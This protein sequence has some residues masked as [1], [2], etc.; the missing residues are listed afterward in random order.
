MKEIELFFTYR[1]DNAVLSYIFAFVILTESLS[2][3]AH[4]SV[5]SEFD[6]WLNSLKLQVSHLGFVQLTDDQK[7]IFESLSEIFERGIGQAMHFI[8]D[9]SYL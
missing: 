8:I 9:I 1:V 4:T 5:S 7:L 2:H 6:V 3:L